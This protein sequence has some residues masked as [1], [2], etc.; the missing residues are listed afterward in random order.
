MT[1]R[2]AQVGM[3]RWGQNWAKNPIPEVEELEV[4]ARV[5]ASAEALKEARTELDLDPERCFLSVDEM[6]RTVDV[7][8]VLITA[9]LPGHVPV[10][11]AALKAG[12]HVLTEKPFAPSVADAQRLVDLADQ[13]DRVLMVSQNYRFFPAPLVAAQLI[14]DQHVGAVYAVDLVF[15]RHTPEPTARHAALV[16]PLLMDMAIHHFDLLRM[17]LGGEPEAVYC[18]SWQPPTSK[19]NDPAA[20]A[21]V[22]QFG[23]GVVIT[24]QGSWV[25]TGPVTPWAGE[26]RMEC[27]QGE[28]LWTSRGGA[29]GSVEGDWVKVRKPGS[30]A[31]S[32]PLPTLRH[33]GRAGSLATFAQT[34]TSG[35]APDYTS[36]GRD[37][38]G[39]L[40]FMQAAIESAAV[41]KPVLIGD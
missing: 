32:V 12:K 28:I 10:A 9:A 19:F 2:I 16:Q 26:W 35:K 13:Q 30:E 24:Y 31:K 22:V 17:V 11:E 34:V 8:G 27:T 38:V 29:N 7:D 15:R 3:G 1:L 37:N 18:H 4:V 41:G 40:K 23:G 33:R 14:A 21:M 5:D 25:S 20:A 39:S 6:L 36:L